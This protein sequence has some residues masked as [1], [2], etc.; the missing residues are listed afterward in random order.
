MNHFPPAD[1]P[2]PAPCPSDTD[3]GTAV[4]QLWDYLDGTLDTERMAVIQA[5]IKAC[6]QC[7]PH[8]DFARAF[9]VAVQQVRAQAT[10]EPSSGVRQ[11][12]LAALKAEGYDGR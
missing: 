10:S 7:F 3:C 1:D 9:L 11:K 2:T 8:A 6:P 5:H 4:R 12:V